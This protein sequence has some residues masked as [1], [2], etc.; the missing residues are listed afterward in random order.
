MSDG[1]A[2]RAERGIAG[3][4]AFDH[5]ATMVAV[6]SADGHCLHANA[7]LE[8]VMGVS[9]RTLM[10]GQVTDWL[11]DPKPLR[12]ALRLVSD[13]EVATG[14]FEGVLKRLPLG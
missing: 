4:E 11:A 7:T 9:R 13:N 14:R 5:L 2:A 12:E 8:S 6:A 3:L 10:R 1:G